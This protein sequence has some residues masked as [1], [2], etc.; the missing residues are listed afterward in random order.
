[1]NIKWGIVNKKVI[2]F[3]DILDISKYEFKA[4]HTYWNE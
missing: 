4:V 1:M 2:I 3:D